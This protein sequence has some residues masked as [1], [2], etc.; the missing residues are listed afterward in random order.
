MEEIPLMK[1][2]D[3]PN[4]IKLHEVYRNSNMLYIVMELCEGG[5]L[6]NDERKFTTAGGNVDRLEEKEARERVTAV[7]EALN[8]L[9][10]GK[11]AHRDLTLDNILLDTSLEGD[12]KLIDFGLSMQYLCNDAFITRV[13][14]TKHYSSPQVLDGL[15]GAAADD[16]WSVGVITYVNILLTKFWQICSMICSSSPLLHTA[17]A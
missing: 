11:C 8:Y 7:L 2:F 9:H 10:H 16:L 13:A 6:F 17:V 3:H 15:A 14:C 1:Q 12:V 5:Q 4:V